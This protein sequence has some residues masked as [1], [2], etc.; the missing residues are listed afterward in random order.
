MCE[1]VHCMLASNIFVYIQYCME[2]SAG[3]AM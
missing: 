3:D 1:N 2:E